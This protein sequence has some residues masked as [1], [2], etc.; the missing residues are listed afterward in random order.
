MIDTLKLKADSIFGSAS[1]NS[2]IVTVGPTFK[3]FN[4]SLTSE[5][6]TMVL[7]QSQHQVK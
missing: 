1:G 3:W 5:I 7:I 2:N 4:N 6:L